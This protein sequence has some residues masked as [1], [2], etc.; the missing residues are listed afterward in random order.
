MTLSW[1]KLVSRKGVSPVISFVLI[2]AVLLSVFSLLFMWNLSQEELKTQRERERIQQLKLVEGESLAYLTIPS[3]T[4]AFTVYN[5]G[6]VAPDIRHVYVDGS[7]T[8]GFTVT[9]D[10]DNPRK[11]LISTGTMVSSS[12]K[13]ETSL[14]NIY[15]YAGPTAVIDLL[16]WSDLDTKVILVL[17]GSKSNAVG[18]SISKW[19]WT[20]TDGGSASGARV[21]LELDKPAEGSSASQVII[22]LTVTDSTDISNSPAVRDATTSITL[23]IPPEGESGS[24][25]G[26]P[27]FGGEGAPGGI[28]ISLGGTGGGTSVA[29]GRVIAFNIKNFSGRMI[30]LTSLRFYGV[31]NPSNYTAD[32][33][34]IAPPGQVLT[35]ADM[36]Y[37]GASVGDG[38][39]AQFTKPYY[40]G[41]RD[42]AHI[43]LRA[44]SGA[45]PQEGHIFMIIM[46]DAATPQSYYVVTVPIRTMDYTDDVEFSAVDVFH[47]TGSGYILQGKSLD[48]NNRKLMS[49]GVAFSTPANAGDP[50]DDRMT[51]FNVAGIAYW[52][53][54]IT[55]GT[56]I[57]LG[58]DTDG[59]GQADTGVTWDNSRTVQFDF[60]F[61]DVA[62][63]FYYFVYRFED[64]TSVAHKIPRFTVAL[65]S[66]ETERRVVDP[67]TG[68]SASWSID[69]TQIDILNTPLNLNITGL[70][71]YCTASFSPVSPMG[72]PN[73][74]TL[75]VDILPGAPTGLYPLVITGNNNNWADSVVVFLYL[76]T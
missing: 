13:I 43:E 56:T 54:S 37:S 14:G 19:E 1:K 46:Y 33:V 64:G 61:N 52:T 75:T 6:T 76:G 69:I 45:R 48:L 15:S 29:E 21:Q 38:G 55:S 53:G 23:S 3:D 41:D 24:G 74:V 30:P 62:Q 50:C 65:A 59:D 18:A 57:F 70:P 40:V 12:I 9:Q 73:A 31:K 68:G 58:T 2:V 4:S 60:N 44:S 71:C 63:R 72:M 25:E 47:V 20:Y 26:D 7:E 35:A 8:T 51:E 16:S 17:D 10:T 67:S 22:T 49:I 5:N 27:G 42:E 28:Y 36:Y 11:W 32:E 34:Y 66:G 39:I